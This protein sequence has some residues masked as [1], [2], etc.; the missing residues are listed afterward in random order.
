M[1]L[2]TTLLAAAILASATAAVAQDVPSDDAR[3][4]AF[5]KHDK[6]TDGKL[7]K[8]EYLAVVTEL[9]FAEMADQLF[10]QRD[11]NKD[12]FVSAEEYAPAIG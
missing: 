6:N 4:A 9:G 5:K 10:A 11:A 7:D 2:A 8:A 1:R 3:M 12:G